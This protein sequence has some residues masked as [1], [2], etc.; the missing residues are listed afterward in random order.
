MVQSRAEP[1]EIKAIFRGGLRGTV[2]RK[3]SISQ[4]GFDSGGRGLT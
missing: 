2:L 1:S 4:A 3:A